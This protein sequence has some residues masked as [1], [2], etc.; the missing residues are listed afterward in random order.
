M[1]KSFLHYNDVTDQRAADVQLFVF[2]LTHELVRVCV[3]ELSH[4]GKTME[5]KI[6]C[7]RIP[8]TA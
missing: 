6:W 1:V 5:I 8:S 2:Y 7:A 3:I 4:M